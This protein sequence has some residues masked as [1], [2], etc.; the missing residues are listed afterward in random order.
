MM[1]LE[2][3]FDNSQITTLRD[4][5]CVDVPWERAENVQ[6]RFRTH[7]IATTLHLEPSSRQARLELWDHIAIERVQALLAN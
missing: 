5:L 4:R 2:G 6:S 3:K 7:G 1:A